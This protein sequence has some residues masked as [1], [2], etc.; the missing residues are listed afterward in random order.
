MKHAVYCGTRNL[1]EGMVWSAKSLVA[2]SSVDEVH[3]LIEDDEFPFEMPGFCDFM[4]VREYAEATFPDGTPNANS[5]FTK[6][7]MMRICYPDLL[8]D[9]DLVLQLDIDTVVLDDVDAL[10]DTPMDGKWFCATPERL[11]GYDPFGSGNYHNVG[12]CLFNL[13]QMRADGA[14]RQ[15]VD[16]INSR[17]LWCVEQDALNI[18]GAM[19]G[20]VVDMPVRFNENRA[21]G[22]TD[23]PAIQHYVGYM[24][25]TTNPNLPRRE[26]LKLYRDKSW[27]EILEM[28]KCR[29]S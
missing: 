12:V 16:L 19:Q 20:K 29:K 1:Y 9:V 7:A 18:A 26:Y 4:N 22:Y 2:N 21:T 11:S 23:N 15:L 24:D 25:W 8:P 28:R 14:Q 17:K 6:M 5:H 3:F 10:W 13:A 27:A